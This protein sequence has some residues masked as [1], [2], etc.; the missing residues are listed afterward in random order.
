MKKLS[1]LLLSLLAGCSP[2]GKSAGMCTPTPPSDKGICSA[3]PWCWQNPLPQGN[4]ISTAWVQDDDHIWAVGPSGT[5]L[6]WD[7]TAW[8]A[9]SSG[10]PDHLF[11]GVWGSGPCDIWAVGENED[12][13]ILH[14]DGTTWTKQGS[15]APF[16]IWGS[17]ANNV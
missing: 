4:K 5:I 10:D 17:D 2:P 16:A 7:G 13:A 6:Y 3:D 15:G 9:Q 11:S 1:L 8:A 14:W 12:N